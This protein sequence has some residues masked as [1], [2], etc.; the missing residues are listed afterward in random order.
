MKLRMEI[1]FF[2]RGEVV[3]ALKTRKMLEEGVYADTGDDIDGTEYPQHVH[4]C[5]NGQ[6]IAEKH[7]TD[8]L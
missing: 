1:L 2:E 8:Q 4:S 7:S 3:T 5:N 6:Q